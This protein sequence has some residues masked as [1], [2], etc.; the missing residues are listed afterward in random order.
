MI[1]RS[2]MIAIAVFVSLPIATRW[3]VPGGSVAFAWE[4]QPAL[5]TGRVTREVTR[6]P[7]GEPPAH[8]WLA[9]AEADHGGAILRRRAVTHGLGAGAAVAKE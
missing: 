9:N 5:R 8:R 4:R 7:P 3:T 6:C 1:E 2:P